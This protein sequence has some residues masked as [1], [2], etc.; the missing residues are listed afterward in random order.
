MKLVKSAP[1]INADDATEAE[2]EDHRVRSARMKRERMRELLLN[3][4]RVAYPGEN[5]AVPAVIDD[6][7][8]HA[9][10]SRSTFYKYFISLEQAVEEL[11]N[12]LADEQARSYAFLYMTMRDPKMRAASG[13]QLFLSRSLIDPAWG[14]FVSHLNQISRDSGLADQI[15]EDLEAGVRDGVFQVRDIDV[16]LD[17]IMGTKIEAVR[18]LIRGLGSRYYIETVAS[19]ILR[20]LGVVPEDADETAA[21]AAMRLHRDAPGHIPWWKPFN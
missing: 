5:P 17:V 7:T 15:R 6:I 19:M 9:G 18:H 2:A 20:A 10:V 8:R 16:A 11:A 1:G 4:V 12:R 14:S 21:I 3:A 13:F